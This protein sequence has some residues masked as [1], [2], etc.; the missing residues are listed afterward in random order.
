M[1]TRPLPPRAQQL[2]ERLRRQRLWLL[3]VLGGV[4]IALLPWSAYLS[5][6][7]PSQH[8]TPH[9]QVAWVGLDLFEAAALVATVVAVLRRSPAVALLAAV[10]GTALLLDAWFDLVTARAGSDF[11]WALATAVLGELPLAALCFWIACEVEGLVAAI[12]VGEPASAAA[13]P[14][15]A[16]P[17]PPAAGRA[18]ARTRRSGAPSEGR[19]SR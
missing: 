14:P 19:T 8:V 9:W 15:T 1:E 12:V 10:A 16:P 2:G 13:P 18:V 3:L 11:R 4:A 17:A 6:T 7:L 5:A